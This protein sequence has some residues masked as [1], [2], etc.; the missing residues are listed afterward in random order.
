QVVEGGR[1]LARG[2]E[3]AAEVA[4][5]VGAAENRLQAIRVEV[6]AIEKDRERLEE[7]RARVSAGLEVCA[8]EVGG[9]AGEDGAVTT[10][11][12]ALDERMATAAQDVSTRRARLAAG[13][14]A[15]GRPR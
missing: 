4:A 6:V 14:G 5:A 11:L 8:L 13:E 2:G 15:R 1:G 9:L 12:G 7:D 3:R 10:E